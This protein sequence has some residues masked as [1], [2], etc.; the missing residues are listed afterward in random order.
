LNGAN[1]KA[2]EKLFAAELKKT[3]SNANLLNGQT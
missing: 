2:G 1:L 3:Q